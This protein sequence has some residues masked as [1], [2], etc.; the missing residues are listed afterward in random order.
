MYEQNALGV[1]V[2]AGG[3]PVS[4][5][6]YNRVASIVPAV[7]SGL[8]AGAGGVSIGRFGWATPD[9]RVFNSRTS[10][11]DVL[12]LVAIQNGD[13]RRVFWDEVSRTWK[14]RE[15]LNL[16]MLSGGPGVW[17][18]LDNGGGWQDRIYADPVDGRL[19]AGYSA[20]LETSRWSVAAP[21]G[22]GGL[23]LITTWNTPNV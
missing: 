19:V 13:W 9:G 7:E 18:K 14:I 12:G 17:V 16:T 3:V 2:H 6:Y 20:G 11:Q 4:G 23:S 10:A 1:P 8:R 22:P 15:G 5:V 21:V